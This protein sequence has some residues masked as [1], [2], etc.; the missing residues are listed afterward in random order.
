MRFSTSLLMFISSCIFVL[1]SAVFV[2]RIVQYPTKI[3]SVSP[4]IL[5]SEVQVSGSNGANDEFVELY[6]PSV[7]FVDLSGWRISRRTASVSGALTT[8]VSSMS[9][10][11]KPHGFFLVANPLY[12]GSVSAD[13]LY[14]ATSSGIASNNTVILFSDNGVTVVD[15]V[16]MGTAE[17][18]EGGTTVV[19][20]TSGQSVER[21][22]TVTSTDVSMN[23]GGSDE[24]EGNGQDTDT[25]GSDFILKIISNPQN[26]SSTEEPAIVPTPTATETPTPTDTPTS[27][28]TATPTNSPTPTATPSPTPTETPEETP[29]STPTLTPTLTMTPTA[30]PTIKPSLTPT[31]HPLPSFTLSCTTIEKTI[32]TPFGTIHFSIP[33]CK[34]VR[35]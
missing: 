23:P 15:K 12:S 26:A 2:A 29:T 25:N 8:L 28:P 35:R 4:N 9:G 22:A 34:L 20:P 30:S 18:N 6:N 14:S 10:S 21:K 1:V 3:Y 32:W 19:V 33:F 13:L 17:D 11:I 31:P 5:I 16:G 24:F 7:N 27:T